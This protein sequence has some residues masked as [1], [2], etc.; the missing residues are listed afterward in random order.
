MTNYFSAFLI[1]FL[2][3]FGTAN[4][5]NAAKKGSTENTLLWEVTGNGLSKPSYVFGT[6]HMMCKDQFVF[7]GKLNY[8]L[9]NTE[10]T[11]LEINFTDQEQMA[12]MQNMM[13]A[14]KKLS[15]QYT[16]DEIDRFKKGIA[17]YGM[18]LEDVDQFSPL[19]LYSTLSM[20][21]FDC[22]P[23]QM[24]AIDLEIMM[25]SLSKG[26]KIDGLETIDFQ[27]KTFRKYL[28][29]QELLKLVE[30]FEKNKKQTQEMLSFYRKEDIQ[31]LS[32]LM[33][34]EELM[35]K[36]QQAVM[37]DERNS[38]W[39]EKIP[40]IM[41]AQPTLF[42]V[43]AGHLPGEKGILKLLRDKGYKVKPVMK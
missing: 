10:A 40:E 31:Q 43:G 25:K 8:V 38:N 13:I 14:N 11:V 23:D 28:S 18:K 22:A 6:F 5:Q 27:A 3:I 36:E 37:L 24:K 33:H 35:N 32:K 15:E 30:N 39:I 9:D 34:N 12:R 29:P 26:H 17:D 21:F 16:A 2:G 20:K 1:F 42:A 4:A 19:A 41:Q 7:P